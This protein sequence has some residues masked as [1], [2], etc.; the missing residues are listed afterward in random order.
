M[1]LA[2]IGGPH[3]RIETFN[4][5]RV[6]QCPARIMHLRVSP[7]A[8]QAI[9]VYATEWDGFRFY[10]FNRWFMLGLLFQLVKFVRVFFLICF[11]FDLILY[12]LC[13]YVC[14][15]YLLMYS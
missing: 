6:L 1:L 10:L 9:I 3:S 7:L 15:V 12:S 13:Y 4:V 14:I 2:I 11:S 5:M 8:F